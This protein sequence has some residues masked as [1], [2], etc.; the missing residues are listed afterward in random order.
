MARGWESKSVEAQ[1]AEANAPSGPPRP[2]LTPEQIQQKHKLEGLHLSRR[3]VEQ[4]LAASREPRHQAMLR[5][6]LAD[7]D[8]EIHAL[9]P[10]A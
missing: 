10:P 5:Q 2:R 4:Q 9:T 8:A 3:R 7:L 6:A 1:Q